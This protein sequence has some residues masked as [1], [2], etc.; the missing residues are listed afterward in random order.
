MRGTRKYHHHSFEPDRRYKSS[1]VARL[2]NYLM[3]NGNKS[4]ARECV[5]TS[6]AQVEAELKKPALE[7]LESAINQAKPI[8]EVKPTRVGGATYQVPV[9]VRQDRQTQLVLRWLRQSLASH[10]G[11]SSSTLLAREIIEA[12]QGTG[13]LVAKKQSL[14]KAAE[15]NRAFVHLGKR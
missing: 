10:R 12:S 5:Y 7:V 3:F 4:A 9:E 2:I 8:M 15:S 14:H 13:R 11:S 1:L 6:L